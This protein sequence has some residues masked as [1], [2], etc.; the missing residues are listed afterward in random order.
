VQSRRTFIRFPENLS[1]R[2]INVRLPRISQ[3][4]NQTYTYDSVNRLLTA[5]E[6]ITGWTQNYLYDNNG[7]MYVSSQTGLGKVG[8]DCA[9]PILSELAAR[10]RCNSSPRR[11]TSTR[12]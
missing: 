1:N 9:I 11:A 4:W 3:T 2:P 12:R 7:N 6:N 8:T 10:W 5:A